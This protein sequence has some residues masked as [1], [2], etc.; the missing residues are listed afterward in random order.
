[1]TSFVRKFRKPATFGVPDIEETSR[2]PSSSGEQPGLLAVAPLPLKAALPVHSHRDKLIYALEH[3]QVTII[4]GE[5]G[6]GK[7][8]QIP[9][10]LDQA[11]W[12]QREQ[13]IVCTEPRRLSAIFLGKRVSE[14]MGV[15]LGERVGYAVRFD[16]QCDKNGSTTAI[17]FA[18]DS[19]LIRETL[20]DPLLSKYSVVIVDEAHERHLQTDVL[21][22]LL[23]KV[24]RQRPS[25]FRVVVTS[26]TVDTAAF[27]EYFEPMMGSG[28]RQSERVCVLNVGGSRAHSQDIAY[29]SSTC[30]NYVQQTAATVL[31]IHSREPSGD[32]LCFLPNIEDVNEVASLLE[33]RLE[34]DQLRTPPSMHVLRLHDHMPLSQQIRVFID[35]Q[36]QAQEQE[37]GLKS[38]SQQLRRCIVSTSVAE[39]GITVPGVRYVVD[40]GFTRY[41]YFDVKSGIDTWITSL[42]S[43]SVATQ[44][45]GRACRT[46]SGRVYRLMTEATYLS[47]EVHD[48]ALPE[49]QRGDVTAAVLQLKAIGIDDVLHFDFMS[50]PPPAALIY[51]LELLYSLG[52]LGDDCA[53]TTTGRRMA[54]LPL[55][56]RMSKALLT[57]LQRG[58]AVEML[59]VAAMCSVGDPFV[60][61]SNTGALRASFQA[62]GTICGAG[63]T[64]ADMGKKLQKCIDSFTSP[65]GD[66][67]SLLNVYNG[68]TESG[69]S[70]RWCEERCLQYQVLQQAFLIRTAMFRLLKEY[71]GLPPLENRK[72]INFSFSLG[73]GME[74]AER[75]EEGGG[76][77]EGGIEECR[78]QSCGDNVDVVRRCLVAG[79]FANAA[80]LGPDG[81]Y[82]TLRGTVPATLHDTSRL[83]A[84]RSVLPEWVIYNEVA[85]R[86]E[87]RK[88]SDGRMEVAVIREVTRVHPRWLITEGSHYYSLHEHGSK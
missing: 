5:T 33:Q 10:I 85:R 20:H 9:Q 73:S 81:R 30:R 53:I 7:S 26:A 80:K 3:Y 60:S 83:L 66:H 16:E 37:Q 47:D 74:K 68:Y 31:S 46:G 45:A 78:I 42:A 11:G 59:A 32:I 79:Y 14:E 12:T 48:S 51:S 40:S 50:P 87:R 64:R 6:C 2:G 8:T 18:T 67:I 52:A 65:L 1:M 49:M 36:A 4:I 62:D 57:S 29:L 39:T 82:H 86:A 54:E 71:E 19:L 77:G 72:A 21:L 25:D 58:C 69:N 70:P 43:R 23:K 13:C 76:M 55:N 27:K 41:N 56:P 44:R 35:P 84:A 22:G 75:G 38:G 63:P 88:A 34:G 15:T 24:L 28:K 17:K 61:Q